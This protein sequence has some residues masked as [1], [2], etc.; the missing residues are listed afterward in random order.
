MH[1]ELENNFRDVEAVN[2]GVRGRLGLG[3]F[4]R[5]NRAAHLATHGHAAGD[6]AGG[7]QA[8]PAAHWARRRV[9]ACGRPPARVSHFLG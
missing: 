7:P 6:R 2:T 8:D 3:R 4:L 1:I 9:F 5:T